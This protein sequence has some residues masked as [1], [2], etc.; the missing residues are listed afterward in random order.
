MFKVSVITSDA[1]V[2]PSDHVLADFLKYTWIF[3]ISAAAQT[4][5]VTRSLSEKPLSGPTDIAYTERFRA[6]QRM[7]FIQLKSEDRE[8]SWKPV[9][10]AQFFDVQTSNSN[11][12][13]Q[14]CHK[15]EVSHHFETT[16]GV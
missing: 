4:I 11:V 15:G 2:K 3:W 13:E 9:H 8:W 5:L 14:T 12:Y 10:H 6:P 16:N 7:K 1:L